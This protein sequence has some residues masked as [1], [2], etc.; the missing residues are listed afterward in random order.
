MN[1]RGRKVITAVSLFLIFSITQVYVLANATKPSV[2]GN[3]VSMSTATSGIL[4]GQLLIERGGLVTL[5]GATVPAGTTIF[6]GAQLQTPLATSATVKI[7][8]LGRLDVLPDTYLT[9]TFDKSTVN[10]V[11]AKGHAFLLTNEGVKGSVMTPDGKAEI[12]STSSVE[13]DPS[14]APAGK[15][16]GGGWTIG[17][18][19]HAGSIAVVVAVVAGVTSA[20][21][22]IPCYRRANPSPAVPGGGECKHHP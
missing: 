17:S 15:G 21:L 18:L 10:V 8:G 20:I 19:S 4:F 11:I 5:N 12:S 14:G 6:S 3:T 7:D 22:F 2:L 13:A 9:L 16:K 1:T